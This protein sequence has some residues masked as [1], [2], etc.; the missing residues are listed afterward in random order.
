MVQLGLIDDEPE[1]VADQQ[2]ILYP[3][4]SRA[5]RVKD[6][7]AAGDTDAE[8]LVERLYASAYERDQASQVAAFDRAIDLV[9]RIAAI[10]EGEAEGLRQTLESVQE[11][12]DAREAARRKAIEMLPHVKIIWEHQETMKNHRDERRRS[13]PGS[14]ESASTTTCI[15]RDPFDR[16]CGHVARPS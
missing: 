10:S 3:L 12:I 9:V 14:T 16:S 4:S 1:V 7:L 8:A 15:P 13:A 11:F 6:L 5:L 2:V